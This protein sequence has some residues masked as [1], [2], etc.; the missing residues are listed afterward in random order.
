M[1][2]GVHIVLSAVANPRQCPLPGE[3]SWV[4]VQGRSLGRLFGSEEFIKRVVHAM[5]RQT[6]DSAAEALK[7]V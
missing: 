2:T 6:D 3:R 7:R 1:L 5:D 4:K